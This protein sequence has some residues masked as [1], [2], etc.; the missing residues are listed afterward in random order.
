MLNLIS[1][2]L[3]TDF[4]QVAFVSRSKLGI[5]MGLSFV[6]PGCLSCV[7]YPSWFFFILFLEQD[8]QVGC[9]G[10]LKLFYQYA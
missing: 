6:P 8:V 10:L 7:S 9:I 3:V 2:K 5:E 1:Y 4:N